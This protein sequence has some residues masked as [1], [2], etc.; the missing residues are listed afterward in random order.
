MRFSYVNLDRS[1]GRNNKNKHIYGILPGVLLYDQG[2][3]LS[4][5]KNILYC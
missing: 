1:W 5:N 2:E 3:L 4:N